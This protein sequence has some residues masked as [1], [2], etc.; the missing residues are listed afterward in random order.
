MSAHNLGYDITGHVIVLK[1]KTMTGTTDNVMTRMV[2]MKAGNG[3]NPA[4]MGRKMFGVFVANPA[5]GTDLVEI[6]GDDIERAA[7]EREIQLIPNV[8]TL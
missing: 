7:T 8:E 3:C 4:G 2:K 6:F 5:M 1:E